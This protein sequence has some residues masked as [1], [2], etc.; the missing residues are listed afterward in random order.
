MKVADW[1]FNGWACEEM[2]FSICFGQHLEMKNR[3]FEI[4]IFLTILVKKVKVKN[5]LSF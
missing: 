5:N 4:L 3:K 1:I 2:I